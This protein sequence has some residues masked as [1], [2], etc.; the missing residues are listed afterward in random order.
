MNC[1]RSANVMNNTTIID[2]FNSD[3]SNITKIKAQYC[4]IMETITNGIL[5]LNPRLTYE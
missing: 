3:N 5:K 4:Q 2:T 1:F